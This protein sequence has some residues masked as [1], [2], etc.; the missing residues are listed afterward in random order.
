MAPVIKAGVLLTDV[1]RR[2]ASDCNSKKPFMKLCSVLE[3]HQDMKRVGRKLRKG[4]D[5]LVN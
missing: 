3:K 2:I 1:E 4:K 5:I